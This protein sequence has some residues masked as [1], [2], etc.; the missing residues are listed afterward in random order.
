MLTRNATYT[1]GALITNLGTL[2]LGNITVDGGGIAT[3]SAMIDNDGI[4]NIDT[5]S[6]L[7]NALCSENG[8]AVNSWNGT[9]NVTER[10]PA[11][12]QNWAARSTR[13]AAQWKSAAAP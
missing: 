7:Q 10:S 5:G 2:T 12:A 4:L 9:V 1:N 13:P 11:A 6:T 8:G 3:A